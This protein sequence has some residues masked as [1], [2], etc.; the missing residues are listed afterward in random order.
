[1]LKLLR[2]GGRKLP[3]AF[4]PLRRSAQPAGER[5]AGANGAA[6]P[7]RLYVK[8]IARRKPILAADDANPARRRAGRLR[9]LRL[10]RA[11]PLFTTGAPFLPAMVQLV[12]ERTSALFLAHTIRFRRPRLF[13]GQ[14]QAEPPPHPV[15]RLGGQAPV[16]GRRGTRPEPAFLPQEAFELAPSFGRQPAPVPRAGFDRRAAE[17]QVSLGVSWFLRLVESQDSM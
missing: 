9:Q 16:A 6:P 11:K 14:R 17:A 4:P 1:M 2:T 7:P 15:H 3:F 5:H 12:S 13:P 10:R 8:E